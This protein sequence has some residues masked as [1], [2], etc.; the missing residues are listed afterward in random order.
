MSKLVKSISQLIQNHEVIRKNDLADKAKKIKGLIDSIEHEIKHVVTN[1]MSNLIL[2][3][4][5]GSGNNPKTPILYFYDRRETRRGTEGVYC[6]LLFRCLPNEDGFGEVLL[7]LT[8]GEQSLKDAMPEQYQ[9]ELAENAKIICESYCYDLK[10]HGFE[11]CTEGE[12]GSTSRAVEKTYQISSMKSDKELIDDI[13]AILNVYTQFINVKMS[14]SQLSKDLSEIKGTS[15][16]R[17]IQA[18]LGQGKYRTDLFFV[19]EGKCCISGCDQ[20][21]L[22]RAS[23]IKPWR[24]CTDKERLD[25]MNGLL[26]TPNLDAVFDQGY[27]SFDNNGEMVISNE[28]DAKSISMLNIPKKFRLTLNQKQGGFMEYHRGNIFRGCSA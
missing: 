26:L 1:N 3:Y 7:T 14:E 10:G 24:S 28:L 18:R 23:H 2:N 8:Q 21:A 15:K 19:W 4:S 20:K 22:L 16:T 27:I 17:L 9:F 11:L 12:L 13:K 5:S 6:I 25:P